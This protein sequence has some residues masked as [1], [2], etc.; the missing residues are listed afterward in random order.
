MSSQFN[1]LSNEEKQKTEKLLAN[2]YSYTSEERRKIKLSLKAWF[3]VIPMILGLEGKIG[4]ELEKQTGYV[5]ENSA[6]LDDLIEFTNQTIEI[7]H[8]AGKDHVLIMFDE[9]DKIT[10]LDTDEYS[11]KQAITFFSTMIPVLSKINCSFVFV[12]NSQYDTL[13]FKS[14]VTDKYY[15]K[16]IKIPKIQATINK[17]IEK[18]IQAVCGNV[19][20][21]EIFDPDALQRLEEFYEKTSLRHLTTACKYAIEKAWGNGSEKITGFHVKDAIFDVP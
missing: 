4:G 12:L 1:A 15:D 21:H 9:T 19:P 16:F 8:N 6:D 11:D 7:L 2:Q 14:L 5:L 13:N 20:L 18:R 17:I 10:D 3:N